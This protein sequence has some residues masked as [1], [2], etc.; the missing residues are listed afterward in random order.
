MSKVEKLPLKKREMQLQ[1]ICENILTLRRRLKVSQPEFIGQF[2]S[3]NGAPLISVS[4]FSN[5]ENGNTTGTEALAETVAKKMQVDKSVF[6]ME[7][8]DFAKNIELFFGAVLDKQPVRNVSAGEALVAKIS[9][10]LMDEVIHGRMRAGSKLPSNRELGERFGV[11]RTTLREALQVLSGIGVITL[12]GGHG[13]CLSSKSS[14]FN[15]PL[16]WAVLLGENSV[17]HLID[18]RNELEFFSA[19][20]AAKNASAASIDAL[21]EI[22]QKMEVAFNEANF[23]AFLDLDMEFHLA[24]AQS[25]G[26]PIVHNLL[27]TSRRMLKAISK[28]GMVSVE[29]LQ[30]IFSEHGEIYSA[31]IEKNSERA[32]DKMKV[33]LKNARLRYKLLNG[34]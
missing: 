2:L 10:W 7:P 9:D 11:G 4:T 32:F 21:K 6:L 27:A 34:V 16:S 13:T 29:D 8:D 15:A 12:L 3:D 25:S 14:G 17:T 33:H 28:S 31:I 22:Y 23:Q 26:N 19:R 20:L 24:I 30:N 1:H 5:I 18:V